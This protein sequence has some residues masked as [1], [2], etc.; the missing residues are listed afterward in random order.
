MVATHGCLYCVFLLVG[1]TFKV[2][3][4]VSHLDTMTTIIPKMW[5]AA[6]AAATPVVVYRAQVWNEAGDTSHPNQFPYIA[7]WLSHS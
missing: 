3:E 5:H 2:G 1:Q 6:A 7:Q 4:G